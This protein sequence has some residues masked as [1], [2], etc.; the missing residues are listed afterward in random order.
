[1]THNITDKMINEV[2]EK[3]AK[4]YRKRGWTGDRES[5]FA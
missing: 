2:A 5:K 3:N 4:K 1:M